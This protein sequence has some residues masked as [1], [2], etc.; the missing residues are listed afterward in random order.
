MKRSNR[1]KL[2]LI[3]LVVLVISFGLYKLLLKPLYDETTKNLK[4]VQELRQAD[5]NVEDVSKSL[6]LKK[7]QLVEKNRSFDEMSMSVDRDVIVDESDVLIYLGDTIKDLS[8]N[9]S[10][11]ERLDD[12][13]IGD[14][15]FSRYELAVDGSY[16]DIILFVDSLYK[17]YEYL[18]VDRFEL[19][20][21]VLTT[22]DPEGDSAV[23]LPY[24]WASDAVERVSKYLEDS[25]VALGDEVIESRNKN[26]SNTELYIVFRFLNKR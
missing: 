16:K 14:Y 8:L 17:E 6:N 9:T 21:N 4:N 25:G 15:S 23:E 5:V 2:M 11:V 12:Y 13:D 26:V 10:Y 24:D 18:Y 3:V 22:I 20:E 19:R 7:A 1:E